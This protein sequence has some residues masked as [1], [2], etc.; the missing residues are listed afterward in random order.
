MNI[1]KYSVA[2]AKAH[3]SELINNVE[4]D[5]KVQIITKN[6]KEVV[7]LL[8]IKEWRHRQK[9]KDSLI[10]FLESSPLK[11]IDLERPESRPRDINFSE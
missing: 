6:N 4:K 10:D 1:K 9:Y 11:D 8:P 3:L 5:N 2:Y 7:V